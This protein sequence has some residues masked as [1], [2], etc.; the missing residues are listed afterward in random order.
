[1]SQ[2]SLIILVVVLMGAAFSTSA[3]TITYTIVPND[4]NTGL[5]G[6]NRFGLYARVDGGCAGLGTYQ[7][8]LN[9]SAYVTI[10][11]YSPL[12]TLKDSTGAFDENIGE[13]YPDM[14]VGFSMYHSSVGG[15]IKGSQNPEGSRFVYGV[16]QT[17]GSLNDILFPGYD[18]IANPT[19]ANWT[20]TPYGVLIARGTMVSTTPNTVTAWFPAQPSVVGNVFESNASIWM[21]SADGAVYRV[22]PEPA[23]M[24]LLALGAMVRLRRRR[25]A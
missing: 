6:T 21:R 7:V 2:R 13:L 16:G 22:V 20:Q 10:A 24:S 1:M 15:L 4:P 14:V 3:A 8:Q 18:T 11:N 25:A 9:P 12:G 5:T 23:T 17:S 19:Q